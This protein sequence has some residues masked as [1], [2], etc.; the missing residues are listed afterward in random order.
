M[1][2]I[3]S[4]HGGECEC[5]RT[6]GCDAVCSD[7]YLPTFRRNLLPPSSAFRME[8]AGSVNEPLTLHFPLPSLLLGLI[9]KGIGANERKVIKNR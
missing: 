5:Y 1:C 3:R 7:R 2:E 6:P 4:S 8:T 9:L